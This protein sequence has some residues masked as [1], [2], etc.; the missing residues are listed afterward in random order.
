MHDLILAL[1]E[2]PFLLRA[3]PKRPPQ[4]IAVG[5]MA[6]SLGG[7]AAGLQTL[8][9]AT[10]SMRSQTEEDTVLALNNGADVRWV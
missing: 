8:A 2:V 10:R 5:R 1:G 4:Q 6:P 9:A 7:Q 3:A